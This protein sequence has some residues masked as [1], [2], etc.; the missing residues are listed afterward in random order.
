L[1]VKITR[2][3]VPGETTLLD[4]AASLVIDGLEPGVWRAEIWWNHDRLERAR[5]FEL[6]PNGEAYFGVV[7]PIGAL[8][9]QSAEERRRAGMSASNGTPTLPDRR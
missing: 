3:G 7:L 9:G 4:P 8:E 1:E 2:N 5:Q 6:A